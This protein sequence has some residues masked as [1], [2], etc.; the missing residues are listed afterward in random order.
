MS[1]ARIRITEEELKDINPNSQLYK[2]A[3]ETLQDNKTGAVYLRYAQEHLQREGEL[4]VDDD[5]AVS[6]GADEGAYVMCWVWVS[7][8]TLRVKGYLEEEDAETQPAD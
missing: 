4:E 3:V 8:D 7:D 5:A 6:L 1:A 2:N